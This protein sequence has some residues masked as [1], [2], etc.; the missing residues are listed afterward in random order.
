MRKLMIG[1]HMSIDGFVSEPHGI[2]GY[3]STNDA[4]LRWI[5]TSLD[6]MDTILLGRVGYESMSRYWPTA[7]GDLAARMNGL[8]KVVFTSQPC[9]SAWNNT[10]MHWATD[11]ATEVV[12]LK[13]QPGKDL[14]VLGGARL[15]QSLVA[16]GVVDEYRLLCH[17]IAL[18]TGVA[19]FGQLITPANLTLVHST[20]FDTGAFAHIYRAA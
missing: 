4:V 18:G 6:D 9:D 16:A 14:V 5:T 15:A 1:M 17:P 20:A 3:A 7:T 13:Q 10:R 8:A 19:L 12:R 11:A 2:P